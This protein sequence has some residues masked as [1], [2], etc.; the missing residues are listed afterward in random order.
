MCLRL[1]SSS[2]RSEDI[3]VWV[4]FLVMPATTTIAATAVVVGFLFV[5][6][7]SFFPSVLR[8]FRRLDCISHVCF[9]YKVMPLYIMKNK[10]VRHRSKNE[11]K[12]GR[13]IA[14]N[15]DSNTESTRQKKKKNKQRA[16][17]Q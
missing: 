12:K 6:S 13:I 5:V 14:F 2:L 8:R 3:Y 9:Y 16:Q 7:I 10:T 15:L 11:K 17:V 4:C 1:I